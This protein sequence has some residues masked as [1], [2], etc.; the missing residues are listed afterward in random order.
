M[1]VNHEDPQLTILH[2]CDEE[3]D[4]LLLDRALKQEN[5]KVRLVG[6]RTETEGRKILEQASPDRNVHPMPDLIVMELRKRGGVSAFG[7]LEWVRTQFPLV[8]VVALTD[9]LRLGD[10][11]RAEELGISRRFDKPIEY[12]EWKRVAREII[13][14]LAARVTP[15]AGVEGTR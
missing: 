13:S 5:P 14:V 8:P 9:V 3:T 7:F 2:L 12:E 11:E 4:R 15:A 6:C 10:A 1:K